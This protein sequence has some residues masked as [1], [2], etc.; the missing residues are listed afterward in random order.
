MKYFVF[1]VTFLISASSFAQLSQKRVAPKE[2]KPV[3]IKNIKYS[4]PTS[5]MGFVVARDLKTDTIIWKKQVYKVRYNKDLEQDVQDVFIDSLTLLGNYLI[6][7]TENNRNY[8]LKI[9]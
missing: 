8:H 2:V 3:I 6:I 5:E 7:H 1:I 4:A 9:N